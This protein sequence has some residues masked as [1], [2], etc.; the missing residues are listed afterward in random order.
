MLIALIHPKNDSN[1]GM[2]DLE[3][4][5][6]PLIQQQLLQ[7][8]QKFL[9]GDDEDDEDD[10]GTLTIYYDYT[11]GIGSLTSPLKDNFTEGGQVAVNFTLESI[12]RP[13]Y[14]AFAPP[15]ANFAIDLSQYDR[16]IFLVIR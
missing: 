9:L 6:P 8:Q 3:F 4:V 12:P 13:R 5:V 7:E 10:L 2:Y 16:V 1:K 11:C 15:N 14:R